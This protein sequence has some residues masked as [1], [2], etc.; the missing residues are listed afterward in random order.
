MRI[1]ESG[2]A[3]LHGSDEER[4]RYAEEN[5]QGWQAGLSLLTELAEGRSGE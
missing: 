5:T 2:F 4:R 3:A 1:V